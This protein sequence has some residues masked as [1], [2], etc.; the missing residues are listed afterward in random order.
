[1]MILAVSVECHSMH[2]V[3]NVD[4]PVINVLYYMVN[5]DIVFTN[6]AL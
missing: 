1:M 4:I 6:I 3:P 5:V 2:R